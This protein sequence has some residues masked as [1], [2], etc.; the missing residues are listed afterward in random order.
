MVG[1][2]VRGQGQVHDRWSQGRGS[3]PGVKVRGVVNVKGRG[4]RSGGLRS[5]GQWG[6]VGDKF[7]NS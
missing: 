1:V 3:M 6:E 2:K 4:S 7:K 5:D